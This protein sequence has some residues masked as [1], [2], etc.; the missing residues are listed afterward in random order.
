[1]ETSKVWFILIIKS[2]VVNTVRLKDRCLKVVLELIVSNLC[3]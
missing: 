2:L 3:T 1:M